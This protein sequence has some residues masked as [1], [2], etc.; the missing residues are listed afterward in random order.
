MQKIL[1][2]LPVC[3]LVLTGC[4]TMGKSLNNDH[5]EAHNI[6]MQVVGK[7]KR[8]SKNINVRHRIKNEDV[9]IMVSGD[10]QR[11]IGALV[12]LVKIKAR[13]MHA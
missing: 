5:A 7:S 6:D 10:I 13:F 2:I 11:P 1:W 4:Q 3:L 9:S 12:S 8:F